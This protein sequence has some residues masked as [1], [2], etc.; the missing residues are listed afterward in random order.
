LAISQPVQGSVGPIIID[1]KP[2]GA[3]RKEQALFSP[4]SSQ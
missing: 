3:V 4:P 2:I 1:E